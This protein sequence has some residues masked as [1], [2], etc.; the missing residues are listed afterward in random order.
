MRAGTVQAH[1]AGAVTPDL[2]QAIERVDARICDKHTPMSEPYFAAHRE[3]VG[4]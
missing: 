1:E 4:V 3:L 2:Q